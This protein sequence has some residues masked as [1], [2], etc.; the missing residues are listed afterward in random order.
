MRGPLAL[1]AALL[2]AAA[3]PALH[4][5]GGPIRLGPQINYGDDTDAGVGIRLETRF[6][7]A[8]DWRFAG[9]FDLFLPDGPLEYWEVN[10]NILRSFRIAGSDVAPY[11]GG[12]MNLAHMSVDGVPNS[13]DTDLGINL[14][15]GLRFNTGTRI[16]PFFELRVE[17]SGGEQAVLTAGLLF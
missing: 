13:D 1:T 5:Q 3:P 11:V 2:L 10:A 17:L 4:A 6:S 12:G 9:S 8:P 15:G 7:S 14:A 16:S